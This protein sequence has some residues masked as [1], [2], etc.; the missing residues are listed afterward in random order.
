MIVTLRSDDEVVHKV[1]ISDEAI[2]QFGARVGEVIHTE[3]ISHLADLAQRTK[4]FDIATAALAAKGRSRRELERS[5]LRKGIRDVHVGAT[6]D[7]LEGVGLIDDAAFARAYVRA[8][9]TG[10]GTSIWAIRRALGQKGVSRE[11]A[12]A[13]IVEVMD[14][15]EVDELAVALAEG[16]KRLRVLQ[17][18]EPT[19]AKRRLTAF[20]ARRGFPAAI[21]RAVVHTL[22][23]R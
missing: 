8:K 6:L 22:L 17:R 1:L 2:V 13:A 15:Q 23:G 7:R 20:L 10:R 16:T 18:L 14:E 21:V 3:K 4:A 19:V 12:D 9:V 5:M 11:Q